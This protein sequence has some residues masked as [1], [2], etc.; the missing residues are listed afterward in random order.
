MK[1]LSLQEV[2]KLFEN[3]D[4]F[5]RGNF[6]NE[7]DFNDDYIDYY[8]NFILNF[9]YNKRNFNY[10]SNIIDLASYFKI[11]DDNLCL[12]FKKM[13]NENYH[14]VIKLSIIVYLENRCL[15]INDPSLENLFLQILNK[16]IDIVLKNQILISLFIVT[17]NE[18]YFNLLLA[19][20]DRTDD[21]RSVYRTLDYFIN[22]PIEKELLR[23]LV[24]N[25]K[26]K[27]R[28][29]NFGEG[30]TKLLSQLEQTH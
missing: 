4:Y 7:Y 23:V 25:V 30:V 16:K 26:K 28:E 22:Y 2:K 9:N 15:A 13:L 14:L 3:K 19:S 8:K 17:K 6:I 11:F 27:H 20:L 10:V 24:D 21:W 18:K 12:K 5:I 1:N 29:K